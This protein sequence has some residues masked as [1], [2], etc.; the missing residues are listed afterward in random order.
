MWEDLENFNHDGM[1][2][3]V[4][5]ILLMEIL[6]IPIIDENKYKN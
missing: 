2:T 6:V 3:N 1:N 4:A 5:M